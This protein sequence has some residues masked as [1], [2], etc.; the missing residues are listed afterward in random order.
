MKKA[1]KRIGKILLGIVAVIAVFLLGTCVYDK[2]CLASE[3]DLLENQIYGQK[4][5]VDG[6]WIDLEKGY[7]SQISDATTVQ[8]NCGHAVFSYEPDACEKA[9]RDFLNRLEK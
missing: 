7:A 2:I 6:Q 8:L 4:V 9:M 5:E 1:S 3:K